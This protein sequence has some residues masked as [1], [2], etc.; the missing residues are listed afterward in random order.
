VATVAVAW[1]S[2]LRSGEVPPPELS[3]RAAPAAAPDPRLRTWDDA[4]E[5]AVGF[6]TAAGARWFVP[7][8]SLAAQ[9]PVGAGF[10]W[11]VELT[12]DW[13]RTADAGNSRY[14]WMQLSLIAAPS[15]RVVGRYALVDVRA[16]LASDLA[17]TTSESLYT[18]ASYQVIPPSFILGLR[19]TYP[20]AE[21][22]PWF[23]L[24]FSSQLAG[25]LVSPVR[26]ARVEPERWNVGLA[27]GFTF[28]LE[29]FR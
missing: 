25:K 11:A 23:G 12:A 7:G 28:E 20:G 2:S 13:P 9:A 22:L 3:A 4:L 26:R 6:R 10:S 17:I 19:A 27:L 24:T 1:Q 5:L 21:S 15:Y 16:G 18:R 29:R 14:T 8:L